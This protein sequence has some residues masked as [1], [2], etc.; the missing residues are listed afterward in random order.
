[1]K[2]RT[3]L[4]L[5]F[6]LTGILPALAIG[7]ISL[8][9]SAASLEA[10]AKNKLVLARE[11]KKFEIEKHFK[12]MEA[13]MKDTQANM[14]FTAGLPKYAEAF[15]QGLQSDSYKS[16]ESQLGSGL[17]IFT[18][19]NG[20]YDTF[21]IDMKGNVVYTM[22]KESDLGANLE[23]GPLSNSGLAKTFKN[24]L[25]EKNIHIQDFEFYAPSNEPAA[26][27]GTPLSSGGEL[28]GVAAFQISLKDINSIMQLRA[29]MGSTGETY[30]V[31]TDKLMRSDS[32]LD[33]KNHSVLA[34]FKNPSVG[35]VDTV[36]A[37]E[38]L[39]G[40]TDVKTI[41]DYNGNPVLS[42][43]THIAA[44]ENTWA[45]LAEI[46][47]AEAFAPVNQLRTIMLIVGAVALG[48]LL[49]LIP[50]LTKDVTNTVIRP[51]LQIIEGLTTSAHQVTSASQQVASS[52]QS[53]S[54]GASQ[55]AASLEETSSTLEEIASMTRQ[56]VEH[57]N[58]ATE[59]SEATRDAVSKGSE[60]VQRMSSTIREMKTAS[61]QTSKI[62]KTIDEIAFQTNLLA[63]NAAVEAARAGDAGRGFAVVAEEV[64]NLAMRS[65]EA[66]K[67]TNSM[68]ESSQEKAEQG[69]KV[70]EEVEGVL[71]KIQESAMKLTGLVADIAAASKEQERGVSQVNAAVTQMDSVT[72]G[73]AAN[74]EETAASSEEL[75]SQAQQ[76]LALVENLTELTG[77]AKVNGG[78][79]EIS[80]SVSMRNKPKALP[81]DRS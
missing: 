17:K 32:Y 19:S 72:Q 76:L 49:V 53:L 66:A 11:M 1:M 3:K 52:S 13:L 56:N 73:N 16:V 37:R 7:I 6:I 29:G 39:A 24:V 64:R 33:P 54:A 30:L 79:V 80:Q 75:S 22:A 74:A 57:T 41:I 9:N 2:L 23:N 59:L 58:Q 47:E 36:G 51:L 35:S 43:Y 45:L 18:E 55:Q 78:T 31:G 60:S 34:S 44:G 77:G 8:Q 48:I 10:E 62:I 28:V 69:V 20:F 12:S 67:T 25:Q 81:T 5:Y 70:T 40:K 63:L 15:A 46:D 27:I 26:F 65:A 38:A 42:A 61:D 21:L 50:L 68:I 4:I 71:S 14:R